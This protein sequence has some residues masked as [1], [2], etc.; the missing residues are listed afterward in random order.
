MSEHD[1][2]ADLRG[3]LTQA[4][5]VIAAL[6]AENEALR[7]R[8]AEVEKKKTPPPSFV[9]PNRPQKAAMAGRVRRVRAAV[10]NHGRRRGTPTRVERHAFATCPDCGYGLQGDAIKRTREVIE[11]PA[12]TAEVVEHQVIKRHCPV[13][14]AWKTPPATVIDGQVLGH[15]RIGV[16]LASLIGTVRTTHRLP[17]AHIQDV[18]DQVYGV[19]CTTLAWRSPGVPRHAG[20]DA[21][22]GA[23]RDR[24][25]DPGKSGLT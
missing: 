24:G 21:C 10:H 6:R 4:V 18:H 7:H 11:I 15:G 13:C 12:L 2:S 9:K 5:A 8:I 19:R 14:P 20:A 3:E 17:L 23:H 1:E 16:R 25:S 22:A